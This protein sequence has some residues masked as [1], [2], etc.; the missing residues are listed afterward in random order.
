MV[1]ALKSAQAADVEIPEAVFEKASQ[2]LWNMYDTKNPGFGH[3]SP[4]RYPTTTAIGVL[5]QQLIGNAN[6]PRH[7]A[8]AGLS[9]RTK[10]QLGKTEGDF[11][12]YGWYWMTQAMARGGSPY[13]EYWDGQITDT[14]V[15]K[16]QQRDGRWL[17]P[18]HSSSE[19]RDLANTPAYS[20]A[21]GALILEVGDRLS[22]PR[23]PTKAYARPPCTRACPCP[24]PLSWR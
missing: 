7:H 23:L 15:K 16:D 12:L 9:A 13:L 8:F 10:G 11:V 14:M 5:C 1:L 3:Q 22:P 2:Y 4:E 24:T 19:I 20:T 18:P 6:D 21:L 17:P